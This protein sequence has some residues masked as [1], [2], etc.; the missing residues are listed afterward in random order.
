VAAS[1]RI[2]GSKM[3]NDEVDILLRNMDFS[4][5]ENRD[6]QEVA[7]YYAALELISESFRDIA[8]TENNVKHLHKQLLKFSNKDDWHLGEADKP[9]KVVSQNQFFS[10]IHRQFLAATL[11]LIFDFLKDESSEKYVSSLFLNAH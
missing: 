3:T 10:C 6:E 7:G 9:D 8:I 2:E 5:L 11:Y 1:T 4:K